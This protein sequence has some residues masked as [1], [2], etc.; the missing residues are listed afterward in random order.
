MWE[1]PWKTEERTADYATVMQ[2]LFQ[3][4]GQEKGQGKYFRW[5]SLV[6]W[7]IKIKGDLQDC[8]YTLQ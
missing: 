7:N 8:C 4:T 2:E 3:P 1:R 5:D 6:F